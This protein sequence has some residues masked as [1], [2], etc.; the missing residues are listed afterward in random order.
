MIRSVES[1]PDFVPGQLVQH[2]RYGYRAV[3]VAVDPYCRAGDTWYQSNQ[4]QPTRNQPWYH[5]L[6]HD[7]ETTTYAAQGNLMADPLEEPIVHPL[8]EMFFGDF[9]D[10]GYERNE[11][12]WAM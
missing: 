1:D 2:K 5:L 3:V 12:P 4:T 10:G 9:D 6:V 11:R 8:L 7:S